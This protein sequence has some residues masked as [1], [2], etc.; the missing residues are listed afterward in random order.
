MI[1]RIASVVLLAASLGACTTTDQARM[2]IG[3]T[4]PQLGLKNSLWCSDFAIKVTGATDVDRTARSWTKHARMPPVPG[5]VVVLTRGR[6]SKA[7]HVGFLT[8]FDPNGNPIVVSGNHNR[9]VG[10]GVYS[11]DRVIGY[12]SPR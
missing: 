7:G 8:G 6:S 5:A 9:R 10:E 3:S 1:K 12:Y 11:K 4:G 2:Y